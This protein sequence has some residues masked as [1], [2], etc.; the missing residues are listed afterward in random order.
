MFALL[1]N[2]TQYVYKC[3]AINVLFSYAKVVII[4]V[5]L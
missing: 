4:M 1:V 3:F 5:F 2:L